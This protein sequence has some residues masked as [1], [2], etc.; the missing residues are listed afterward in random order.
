MGEREVEVLL[1]ADDAL[2]KSR[3][4]LEA[5]GIAC[6]ASNAARD[7]LET[8]QEATLDARDK[9]WEAIRMIHGVDLSWHDVIELCGGLVMLQESRTNQI[10]E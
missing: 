4:A 9:T 6:M 1:R 3:L 5:V 10:S 7:A 2:E 8:A